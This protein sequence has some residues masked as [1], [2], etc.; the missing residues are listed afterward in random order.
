MGL[1][2]FHT[3]F[4]L[5]HN[6]ICD[7]LAQEYPQ[8]DDQRLFDTARLINCALMAKIHTVEWTPAIVPH[9]TV[10]YGMRAN[11][12]GLMGEGFYRKHGRIGSGDFF[13]VTGCGNGYLAC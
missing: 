13:I 8:W 9:P 7:R 1:S 11:W 3:T 10:H 4:V 2:L 6:S 12:W 5:E